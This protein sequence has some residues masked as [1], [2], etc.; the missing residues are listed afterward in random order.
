MGICDEYSWAVPAHTDGTPENDVGHIDLFSTETAFALAEICYSLEE[1]LDAVTHRRV[2][3]EIRRRIL[4]TYCTRLS[5]YESQANNWASVCGGNVGGTMMYLD[6]DAFRAHMPRVLGD[7][8]RFIGDF[9][10]EGIC[11]EGTTYWCYGFSN[12]VWFADMLFNFSNGKIDLMNSEKVERIAAYMQ[13]SFLKGNVTVSFSDGARYGKTSDALQ[14]R[15]SKRFPGSVHLLPREISE[16]WG[17]NAS[18]LHLT[19]AFAYA[20]PVDAPRLLP[21]RNYDFPKAGQVIVNEE[22]YSLFA[23]AG[24][25]NEPHNHN[26]VGSFILSTDQGQV[27]CDIGSGLYTRQ[28]FRFTMHER[29]AILCNSSLGHS[30]PVI[31]GREQMMGCEYA[32]SIAHEG[33]R[34]AIEMAGAYDI[35]AL[36]RLSRTLEH[37]ANGVVLT[38]RFEGEI[39]SFTHRFVTMLAPEVT[40]NE[41]RVA[42]VVLRFDPAQ[43]SLSVHTDTHLNHAGDPMTVYLL[44]FAFRAGVSEASFSFDIL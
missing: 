8:S 40:E 3:M 5:W 10:D 35:P 28:Y 43:V 24:H 11:M 36:S 6:P 41:V 7:M 22:K 13:K 17:G 29:Y 2:K 19:H 21:V 37:S 32:G 1:C 42:N 25:N 12:F 9:S 39:D 26:D 31:N 27:F 38:D 15:L 23:K 20:P 30:V 44:D 4:D 33:N 34:I 16:V 18:W 14:Y